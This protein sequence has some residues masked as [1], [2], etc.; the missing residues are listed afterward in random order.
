MLKRFLALT[1]VVL[2][3]STAFGQY[4]LTVTDGE[5]LTGASL[6]SEV[7]ADTSAGMDVA[8][9]SYGVCHDQAHLELVDAVDGATTLIVNNGSP[10]DFDQ[11]NLFAD[12]YNV[13]VVISFLGMAV[14]A[15]GTDYELNVATY[16]MLG[17]AGTTST[18]SLC[19]TLGMPPVSVVMVV[20]GQ[21]V[22]PAT[23]EG[24]ATSTS[25]P[26]GGFF[27]TAPS[28]TVDYNSTDGTGSFSGNI[29]IR[30]DVTTSDT[31][32]FSAGL[33]SDSTYL[34]PTD[35]VA[36]GALADLNGG[37]GPD[38]FGPAVLADGVT[39]GTVY[40]FLSTEVLVFSTSTDVLTVSY[41]LNS[42]TLMGVTGM[43]DTT[44][45]FVDTL[46][47]PPVSN[48]VVVNGQSQPATGED[49]T[50]TLNG[51][52]GPALAQF[53]RGECNG[54]GDYDIADGVYLLNFLHMGGPASSCPAACDVNDDG[55]LDNADAISSFEYLFTG[56]AA[57]AAP[58]PNCGTDMTGIGG[59][60]VEAADCTFAGC[61]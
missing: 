19:G 25:G 17:A 8:G 14:L 42:A 55:A 46:G 12:G 6:T 1:A 33:M 38:F 21:S 49:G 35:V 58:F 22:T 48:V 52:A 34:T 30:E 26:M 61:P 4:S 24:T 7:I 41:D 47:A 37:S 43:T 51:T 20:G 28:A 50:I 56:G 9:W 29:A 2:A 36:T 45:T 11:I 60:P 3:G 59:D 23:T 27:Y 39:V 57:P 15:P 31:Q 53:I 18:M 10:P 32:G 40:S 5:A 44:L 16:N 54:E 13:G